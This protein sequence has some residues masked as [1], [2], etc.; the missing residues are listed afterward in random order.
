[1][2]T[3]QLDD[4]SLFLFLPANR[5]DRLEKAAATAADAIIIDLEDAVAIDQKETARAGLGGAL[6][7]ISTQKTIV[8]RINGTDTDWY[9]E[10]AEAVATLPVA[11]VMLPKAELADQC[12][13]IARQCRKPLI[14]LIETARGVHNAATI[15]Q[16]ADRMAFG[17]L[18]FAADLSLEQDRMALAYARSILAVASR[19]AGIAAPIDGVTQEFNDLEIVEDD[20]RHSRAMGFGGKLLIHP[21]QIDAARRAFMPN[22]DEIAWARRIV[23]AAGAH[24]GV[25][26]VDGQMVDAPVLKRA[27]QILAG[28]RTA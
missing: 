9:S 6:D 25:L 16:S 8:V 14:A 22:A 10:D 28:A 21:R 11:A 23:E 5:L 12:E 13:D 1:M 24:T 19:V 27:K 26:T 7:A 18:D 2:T 17:N 20:A 4:L 3:M 15:A